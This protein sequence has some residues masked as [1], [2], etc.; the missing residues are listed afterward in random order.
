MLYKNNDVKIYKG[1]TELSL[2]LKIATE[3]IK[4]YALS[5]KEFRGYK[6]EILNDK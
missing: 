5:G 3:T 4:K 2:S 6:F 1:I